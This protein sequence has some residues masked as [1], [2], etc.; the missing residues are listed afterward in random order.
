MPGQLTRAVASIALL[1]LTVSA[2][3]HHA[4]AASIAHLVD[5]LSARAIAD[6]IAPA[7]GVAVT[8]DGKTILAKSYGL[9]D[10]TAGIPADDNTLWYLASTSKSFTGFGISLLADKGVLS[11][12][13]PITKLLPGVKWNPEVHADSLTLARF[14]SH[15]HYINDQAV[16]SSAAFTGAIPESRWPDLIQLAGPNPTHDLVYSN[17]GYNVAAMV[18]DRLRPEGWRK[19]LEKN[20]NEP[21]GLHQTFMRIS[22]I[23]PKRIAQ[24][25][26]FT[27]AG[28]YVTAPFQ[29]SDRTMNS[30]GGHI[31]TVHDLARWTIVQMDSGVIDGKRVF[32]KGAV[33]LSQTLIA[34]HTR[35]QS[36]KFAFFDREGWGAGWD[37]GSYEGERMVSRFGS[38]AQTRSHLSFLPGRRIGVVAMSTGGPSVV[39]DVIAA[40]A[41]DLEAGRPDAAERAESRMNDL[42]KAVVGASLGI[43]RQDS[44][45]AA[46]QTQP[47][48]HPWEDFE[49]TY[50]EPAYGTVVFKMCGGKLQYRWGDLYGPVEIYDASKNQMRVIIAGSGNVATFS[51]P[52]TGAAQSV[53]LQGVTFKRGAPD[54]RGCPKIQGSN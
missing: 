36:K 3:T 50:A 41:Y 48:Q 5:S 33:V 21:A 4:N 30:A 20:V 44:T 24:P 2:Q 27:A 15:T 8:M 49:G 16:V 53:E 17:F 6:K 54:G 14:L 1:P 42:R 28:K 23:D 10:V 35:D 9:A 7:L 43:A 26:D 46:R 52:Q 11:F 40:Y 45:R 47:L 31:S 12:N 38:Y 29:K 22:G 13:T 39:T 51:F 37:I 25:G 34:K 18:I 32:P 19:Y